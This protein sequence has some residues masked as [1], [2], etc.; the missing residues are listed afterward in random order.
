M[1]L[2]TGPPGVGRTT[3][4]R[5]AAAILRDWRL[6]GFYTEEIRGPDGRQG[7]RGV[8]FG[9][10]PQVVIARADAPA[11]PMVDDCTVDVAAIDVIAAATLRVNPDEVDAVLVDEIGMMT[12]L[13][14]QFLDA[15]TDLLDAP[16]PVV[17]AVAQEGNGLIAEVK[18]RPEAHVWEVTPGNRERLPAEVVA[19]LQDHRRAVEVRARQRESER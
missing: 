1:L 16:V 8:S 17:A 14:S 11:E 7:F 9:K 18:N 12:C 6:T 19:W 15:M 3:A 13:S 5:E 4:L 10:G 2:L